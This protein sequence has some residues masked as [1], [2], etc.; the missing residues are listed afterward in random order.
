MRLTTTISIVPVG[1]LQ[2]E[3]YVDANTAQTGDYEQYLVNAAH[4]F[5]SHVL[6]HVVP[7]PIIRDRLK[8]KNTNVVRQFRHNSPE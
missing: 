5:S 7:R 1:S 6:R 4:S 8:L 2:T 3:S